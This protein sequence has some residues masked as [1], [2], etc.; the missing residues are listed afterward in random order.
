MPEATGMPLKF[1]GFRS[2]AAVCIAVFHFMEGFYI[3]TRRHL[4]LG[5]LP[6]SSMNATVTIERD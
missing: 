4:A 2:R 3:P 6:P 5:Y 1:F